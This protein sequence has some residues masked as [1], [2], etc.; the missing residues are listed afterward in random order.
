MFP[1]DKRGEDGEGPSHRVQGLLERMVQGLHAVSTL[2]L[3]SLGGH[4]CQHGLAKAPSP[5]GLS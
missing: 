3:G 2:H 1:R 4:K 5:Q